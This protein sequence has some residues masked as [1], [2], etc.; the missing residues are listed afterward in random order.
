[1][2]IAPVELPHLAE[3]APAQIALPRVSQIRV[4]NALDAA[5]RVKPRGYLMGDALVLNEAVFA[6]G[7]NSLL[8]EAHGVGVPTF[9][10]G[11]LGRHQSV[12]VGE[13][14][15]IVLSP[16]AQLFPMRRQ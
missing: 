3:P 6:S 1:M 7:L 9:D 12:F 14:R 15:W 16:L 5:R 4:G 2:R 10:A 8:V 13:S 11:D